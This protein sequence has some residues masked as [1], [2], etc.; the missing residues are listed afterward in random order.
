MLRNFSIG[1]RSAAAFGVIG[2]FVLIVGAVGIISLNNLADRFNLIVDHRSPALVS[3]KQIE[4]QFFKVRL[5]NANILQ[6]SASARNQYKSNYDLAKNSLNAALQRMQTLAKASEAQQL[7]TNISTDI[8]QFFSLQQQQMQLLEQGQKAAA[9][10]MQNA[11]MKTIRERT[12]GN[13]EQLEAFQVTRI[14]DSQSEARDM[15]TRTLWAI[16][17]VSLFAISCVI[18]FAITFTRAIV[19]PMRTALNAAEGIARGELTQH[20]QDDAKDE[21]GIMLRA[22]SNMQSMLHG[23]ISQIQHASGRLS[24]TAEQLAVVTSQSSHGVEQQSE[25]L[26]QS[27]AAVT[28]L[29]VSIDDVA[30]S[31]DATSQD[32]REAQQASIEGAQK[33]EES[34]TMVDNLLSNLDSS[35]K[36]LTTL[37]SDIDNIGAVLDVIRAIADQTNLLALNAAIEAARAG[38]SGRGFAVVADEVRAL[39]HRTQVSTEEIEQMIKRLQTGSQNTV[40]AINTSF[41]VAQQ[42]QKIAQESG[43]ALSKI[44]GSIE[45][46]NKQ[47]VSVASTTEEQ[48]QVSKDVDRSTLKIKALSADIAT[49]VNNTR[50]SS[51]ELAKLAENLNGLTQQFSV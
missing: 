41:T 16:A 39:A 13:I 31:A 32:A 44:T 51:A 6:A 36:G 49:G 38:E 42:T 2:C 17:L 10:A 5:E 8:E 18:I 35:V 21:T 12:A 19:T 20:I 46:M 3:I 9:V 30:R 15:I 37:A 4:S 26:E 34:L 24:V 23:T 29:S 45:R 50:E 43:A 22:L 1:K 33:V 40:T 48:A 28:Q 27:S 14:T 11:Q 7:I 47:T 25:Q